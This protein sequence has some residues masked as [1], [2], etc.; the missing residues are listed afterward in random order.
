LDKLW[1]Q[2]I[3]GTLIVNIARMVK[4]KK[5][6]VANPIRENILSE[7]YKMSLKTFTVDE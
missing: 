7:E 5:V 6:K 3:L 1:T 2:T 4:G